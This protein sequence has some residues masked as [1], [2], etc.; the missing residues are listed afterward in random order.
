MKSLE[1]ED[2]QEMVRIINLNK[3]KN[4]EVLGNADPE[5]SNVEKLYQMLARNKFTTDDEAA[6]FF[7]QSHAKDP[8][9]KK[10]RAKLVD[11]LVSTAFFIDSQ[12][13]KFSELRRALPNIYKEFSAIYI[14]KY[15]APIEAPAHFLANTLLEQTIK[16]ELIPIVIELL[17]LL[18]EFKGSNQTENSVFEKALLMKPEY[19]E[20]RVA[21]NKAITLFKEVSMYFQSYQSPNMDIYKKAKTY[22]DE[23]VADEDKIDTTSYSYHTYQIGTMACSSIGD[24]K[25]GLELSE[26]ILQKL[27]GRP[28]FYRGR[29]HA[30][31]LQKIFYI[32]QL[33]LGEAVAEP[34]FEA[35]NDYIDPG[36]FNW[37]VSRNVRFYYLLYLKRYEDAFDVFKSVFSIPE[38]NGLLEKIKDELAAQC[39]LLVLARSFGVYQFCS[40]RGNVRRIQTRKIHEPV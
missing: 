3:T 8:R 5:K 4:I 31:L 13:N 14:L 40:L 25:K 29:V 39:R 35:I 22:Y 6:E 33:K 15:R 26:E 34:A 7:F 9:Y 11:M 27:K 17:A 24:Y 2:L 23:L 28:M 18:I 21:E 30:V 1:F 19:E 16:Y 37:R 10:L 32:T 38:P 20:K 36:T 12:E